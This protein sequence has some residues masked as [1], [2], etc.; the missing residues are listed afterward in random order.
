MGFAGKDAVSGLTAHC[1]NNSF[2][3]DCI[4]SKFTFE[5]KRDLVYLLEL[6]N[7]AFASDTVQTLKCLALKV[8]NE[9]EN[10]SWAKVFKMFW[11]NSTEKMRENILACLLHL[12]EQN[13]A[14][15]QMV[16]GSLMLLENIMQVDSYLPKIVAIGK[17][18]KGDEY[19]GF[20]LLLCSILLDSGRIE[21]MK[22]V[23]KDDEG[24]KDYAEQL[25]GYAD[26]PYKN[27]L[28]NIAR[29]EN[30]KKW[31]A[32]FIFYVSGTDEKNISRIA[33]NFFQVFYSNE[34]TSFR[35]NLLLLLGDLAK[36]AVNN[37]K[38]AEFLV[39]VLD[40]ISTYKKFALFHGLYTQDILRPLNIYEMDIFRKKWF[41]KISTRSVLENTNLGGIAARGTL[42]RLSDN[43]KS[44]IF[45]IYQKHRHLKPN[46][47]VDL[48][49][50]REK[51]SIDDVAHKVREITKERSLPINVFRIAEKLGLTVE[52]I[53]V[54]EQEE[55]DGC[56]LRAED[57]T[58]PVIVINQNKH[59]NRKRFTIGH[60]IGHYCLSNHVGVIA[61][62]SVSEWGE[63]VS[64][65]RIKETEREADEFASS[66][67]MPVQSIT[68]DLHYGFG[69]WNDIISTSGDKYHVSVTAFV[70]RAI[71]FMQNPPAAVFRY[72]DGIFDF[73]RFSPNFPL[74]FDDFPDRGD[75]YPAN[76]G[77]CKIV[78]GN[79]YD[80]F[81]GELDLRVWCKAKNKRYS[82]IQ[83]YSKIFGPWI[84]TILEL[85]EDEEYI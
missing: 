11:E 20:K 71:N 36:Q 46:F 40:H 18:V 80:E 51:H 74:S 65:K 39:Q 69:S 81:S 72:N 29:G 64:D 34:D 75:I 12:I 48:V 61:A 2:N 17:S 30:S 55:F 59:E 66:L 14:I 7:T 47:D 9:G 67:L 25:L 43:T 1:E 22:A 3:V 52:N 63:S 44:K 15:P 27:I 62:C 41:Q 42:D 23:L 53:D 60:E 4:A 45:D 82:R 54:E 78:K 35:N 79:L 13:P 70:L 50:F 8:F 10:V 21:D 16:T 56:L 49:V 83:E 68:G 32:I 6:L 5:Q 76:S 28:E 24:V 33:N 26:V 57:L 73:R 77:I 85:I 37:A 19:R 38:L 58:F 31:D 84:I